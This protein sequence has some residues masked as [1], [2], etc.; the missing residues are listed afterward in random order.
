MK[1]TALGKCADVFNDPSAKATDVVAAGEKA[2][3]SLYNG[4]ES[5]SLDVLRF[6]R[7]SEK[8]VRNTVSIKPQ[9]LPPTSAAA[10]FH[11][12]RAYYQ[13]QVWRGNDRLLATEWGWY[14]EDGQLLPILTDLP[15]APNTVLEMVRCN[16]KADCASG[17]CS[18]RSHNL[19]CS[20]ACGECRGSACSNSPHEYSILHEFEDDD[21]NDDD[22]Q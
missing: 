21:K 8:V 6:K 2:T 22:F 1:G 3:V 17:R 13:T 19:D 20:P 12:M 15:P 7:F 16:C 4:S 10:K 5:D 14:I 9:S 18:C 11:S